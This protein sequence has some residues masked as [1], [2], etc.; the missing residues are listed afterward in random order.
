VPREPVT[1]STGDPVDDT[2][3]STVELIRPRSA[4]DSSLGALIAARGMPPDLLREAGRRL[5][6]FSLVVAAAFA[7][8]LAINPI[9]RLAGWYA[10]PRPR[11]HAGVSVVMIVV[12]LMVAWTARK[13]LLTPVR[14]IDLGLV[15]EVLVAFGIAIG[16]NL[17]PLSAERPLETISWLCVVIAMFP[18]V[19]PARP[20]R[21][22]VAGLAAASTWPV[23]YAIGV[24]MGNP[25]AAATTVVLVRRLTGSTLMGMATGLGLALTPVVWANATR[26]DPHP[27]H[28]AFVALLLVFVNIGPLNAA[29]ANV[30]PAELRARGFAVTTLLM[31]LLG[32]AASPWLIGEVSDQIGLLTPVLVTGCLLAAAGA[33]L[34]A[35][36]A[37]LEADLNAAKAQ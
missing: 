18:L 15:Y 37:T 10:L 20:A 33:I 26:A 8:A 5:E 28:L 9:A 29:M 7:F 35:G 3:V 19:V 36:R 11:T 16:D 34:L 6:L 25:P 4:S 12:S 14:L 17:T 2:R 21:T 30:L 32:D 27:I 13:G 24:R 1:H 22:I 23:A 31:H